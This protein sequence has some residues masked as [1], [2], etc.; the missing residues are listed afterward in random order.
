[1]APSP[2]EASWAPSPEEASLARSPEEA[3]WARSPEE[4]SW[5]PYPE[6]ASW[7]RSP[8]EAS[9]ARSFG[10]TYDLVSSVRKSM[11]AL[12]NLLSVSSSFIWILFPTRFESSSCVSSVASS[13]TSANLLSVR[14]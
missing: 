7:A 8:E 2:E 12:T 4:A 10:S 13:S 3:S 9:W 1:M 11:T 5:A 14:S 6:E